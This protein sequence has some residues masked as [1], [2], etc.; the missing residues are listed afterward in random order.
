[1]L[2][3]DAKFWRMKCKKK[4][5]V[6]APEENQEFKE[7]AGLSSPLPRFCCAQHELEGWGPSKA[8]TRKL[9]WLF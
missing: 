3:T 5:F 6:R 1:M 9:V 8:T 4:L 7:R 2:K